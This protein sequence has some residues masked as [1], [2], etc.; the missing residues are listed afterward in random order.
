MR[1]ISYFE[2]RNERELRR[3]VKFPYLN[4]PSLV[5]KILVIK[6]SALGDVLIASAALHR[7]MELHSDAHI[8][9][10][11]SRAYAQLFEA[12]NE[13]EVEHVTRSDWPGI[14]QLGWRLHT[15]RFQRVY[16]LQGNKRSRVLCRLSAAPERIGLW[17]GWPYTLSSQLP[18][19]PRLHPFV[20]LNGVLQ[21]VKAPSAS[22]HSPMS[23]A[24]KH[25]I[26]AKQWLHDHGVANK[27]LILLHAGCSARWYTKRWIETRF[28]DLAIELQKRGCTI[29]WVGGSDDRALNARLASKV[30]LNACEIFSIPELIALAQQAWFAIVNDSAPMHA[31]AAANIPVYSLFGPTDWRLSHA[32]G[33]R[34]RVIYAGVSCS[35]CFQ[36]ICP[37]KQDQH[38]CMTQI[39][40][41]EVI[42]R[43][44][45]DGLLAADEVADKVPDTDAISARD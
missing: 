6:L 44:R 28:M 22:E 40:V 3:F 1:V 23:I 10:L 13:L 41:A 45:S 30:G 21:A 31:M 8:C 9:L 25:K 27:N 42:A 32:L 2:Y 11:T 37:L 5:K 18:R 16:D 33:Q 39:H 4:D 36:P 20:R 29:I 12:W 38:R 34:E 15:Q 7:I 26:T 17:P 43:L 14:L 24:E 35:P 19:R